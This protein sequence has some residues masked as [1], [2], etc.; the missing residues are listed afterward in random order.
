MNRFES[1][2]RILPDRWRRERW[3]SAAV[4]AVGGPRG[5]GGIRSLRQSGARY[6]TGLTHRFFMVAG[7]L[8][9]FLGIKQIKARHVR[10]QVLIRAFR[11]QCTDLSGNCFPS[12]RE[13][14]SNLWVDSGCGPLR[15]FACKNSKLK[16]KSPPTIEG[17]GGDQN[18]GTFRSR[19]GWLGAQKMP[20]NW[21]NIYLRTQAHGR[22]SENLSRNS[23]WGGGG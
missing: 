19:T 12:H 23:G 6:R 21:R 13:G 15:A 4:S 16:R 17:G 22:L 2:S 8:N 9:C 7:L 14:A 5:E 20:R 3:V 18:S 11:V 10:F 1:V